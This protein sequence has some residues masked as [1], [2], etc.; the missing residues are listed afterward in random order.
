VLI[1]A[2]PHNY[3]PSSSGVRNGVRDMVTA[4][5]VVGNG[6]GLDRSYDGSE[7]RQRA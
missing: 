3:T 4:D 5:L 6:L 1:G 2:D 7:R